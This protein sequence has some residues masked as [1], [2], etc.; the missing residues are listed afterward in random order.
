MKKLLFA[1][2]ILAGTFAVSNQVQAQ[3]KVNLNIDVQPIWG[4]VGYDYVDYYYL[5]DIEVY[6]EVPSKQYVYKNGNRWVR[7]TTLPARYKN[8]DFY[9]AH[10]VVINENKPYLRHADNVAKYAPYKG[11]HD[12]QPIRD[13]RD[14]RY[15]GN[16]NHPQY[17]K[18]APAPAN[19]KPGNKNVRPH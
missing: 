11:K 1:A 12:Q 2:F 18:P 19:N 9:S 6:Y 8:F 3:V 5:P 15:F 7:T 17:K 16:K 10:K 13:S 14:E 4:P